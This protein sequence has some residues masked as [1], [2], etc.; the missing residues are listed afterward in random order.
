MVKYK[1]EKSGG[2]MEKI[3]EQTEEFVKAE[4]GE[5][6]TGH[7]YYHVDRVRKLA[8][9]IA[10]EERKG[11][12]FTIE[13]AALL[14][15]IPDEKLNQ[16]IED[17]YFKLHSFLETLPLTQIQK[18]RIVDII[19]K[20]SYKGGNEAELTT[21][22]EKVVRDADRIDAM[23]AIGIARAFSYGGKNGQLI[24]D[25]NIKIRTNITNKQ[26][27][28]EKSTSIHHFYEK[29]LVLKERMHTSTAKRI[30][31]ERHQWLEMYLEQFFK[32]WNGDQ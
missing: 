1:S 13:M 9:Y 21:F 23:G 20:I 25:P 5:D 8:L 17:G 19:S 30:A 3:I 4:L 10:M 7:D 24:F 32:E 22:E 15:D 26:Y 2:T 12:L 18:Q 11:D 27:R 14:H 31:E 16:S 28:N 29:L 6:A